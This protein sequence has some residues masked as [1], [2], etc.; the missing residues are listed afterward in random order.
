MHVHTFSYIFQKTFRCEVYCFNDRHV[1]ET[2]PALFPYMECTIIPNRISA[3]STRKRNIISF[4]VWLFE[5]KSI[6][7]Q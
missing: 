3:N 4:V 1:S 2:L 5:N 7:F 6:N